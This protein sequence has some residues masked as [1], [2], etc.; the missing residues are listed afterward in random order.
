MQICRE[1]KHQNQKN[2]A[3]LPFEPGVTEELSMLKYWRLTILGR[4][5]PSARLESTCGT[6]SAE[7]KG[8]ALGCAASLL[9]VA[10]TSVDLICCWIITKSLQRSFVAEISLGLFVTSFEQNEM[11]SLLSYWLFACL[12]L[13]YKEWVTHLFFSQSKRSCKSSTCHG[14]WST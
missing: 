11:S 13:Q 3:D 2:W 4:S 9:F 10:S 6:D 14:W 7:T 8:N 5:W 1:G 12:I